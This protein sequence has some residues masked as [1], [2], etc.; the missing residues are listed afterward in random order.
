[1]FPDTPT[2]RK[3][4]DDHNQ[5]DMENKPA[6][7][8]LIVKDVS[9]KGNGKVVGYAKWWVP[10]GESSEKS[11]KLMGDSEFALIGEER[12]KVEERYLV[13]SEGDRKL[14]DKFFGLMAEERK[15]LMGGKQYYCKQ[16][17]SNPP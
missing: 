1:M 10:I 17:T 11:G 2:V 5:D 12:L 9:Q 3:W 14:L 8:Y 7:K 6:A 13:W 15:N 16:Y 4:W